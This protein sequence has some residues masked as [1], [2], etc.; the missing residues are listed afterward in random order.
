ME[1]QVWSSSHH[2]QCNPYHPIEG[3]IQ[4]TGSQECHQWMHQIHS[5]N[6]SLH[7]IEGYDRGFV[8]KGSCPLNSLSLICCTLLRNS[9][10]V[11]EEYRLLWKHLQGKVRQWSM[12]DWAKMQKVFLADS[13]VVFRKWNCILLCDLQHM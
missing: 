13:H 6:D 5:R 3:L 10:H 2:Q 9:I 12:S 4:R 8:C 1:P 11:C 7:M